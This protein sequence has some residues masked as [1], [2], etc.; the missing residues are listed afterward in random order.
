MDHSE[1][2]DPRLAIGANNPPPEFALALYVDGLPA[3]LAADHSAPLADKIDAIAKR[4]NDMPTEFATDDDLAKATDI[5]NDAADAW[6][7]FDASRKVEKEPYKRGADAVDD[8]YREPLL[9]LK[10][11]KDAF[12]DRATKY[13]REKKRKAD[14]AADA[15]RK[16][17]ADIAEANRI[18]AEVAKEFD[19]DEEAETRTQI[20]ETV[21]ARIEDIAPV[22]TEPVR[23]SGGGSARAKAE[24]TFEIEDIAKVDLNA[25]RNFIAPDAV[26]KALKALVKIQKGNAKVEGVRFF[27]DDK[28]TFRRR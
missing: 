21:E 17:L 3:R 2:A 13:N 18:A 9:R 23:G 7:E 19:D 27:E 4:A 15:E 24:W 6:D 10:R 8:F 25:L 14:A 28:T 11:I 20:A 22:V 1:A 5:V 16:R 12:T 26:E